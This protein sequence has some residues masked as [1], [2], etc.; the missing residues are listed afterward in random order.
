MR[1]RLALVAVLLAAA[2]CGGSADA[3]AA[4]SPAP[5]TATAILEVVSTQQARLGALQAVITASGSARAVRVA[6]L[7]AD[8]PGRIVEIF[9]DVGDRVEAEY[10]LF[11]LDPVPYQVALEEARA[12]LALARAEHSNAVQEARRVERLVEKKAI[13]HQQRDRQR[14]QA[15]VAAARVDQMEARVARMEAD[16]ARTVVRAPFDGSVV[17]RRADEGAMAGGAPVIVLQETGALEVVLDIPEVAPA[18]VRVGDRVRLFV[19]GLPEPLETRVE[20]TSDRIDPR[21]RTYEVRAPVEDASQTLKSG[22][23]VRAEVLPTPTWERPIVDRSAL[24]MRDGRTFVFR[25]QDDRVERVAVRTGTLTPDAAEIV[26]GIA[27][28]DEIVHG[29][30]V[31][32]LTDGARV[33]RAPAAATAQAPDGSPS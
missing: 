5:D 15:L 20:R 1:R 13:S 24:L 29:E 23:W 7:A 9:V 19:D 14:T 27:A 25:L 30:A 26:S 10:P 11:R 21:T 8:V 18:P 6:E 3:P 28:G 31:R 16:L 32:R 2:G 4:A 22:S 17:E 33:R 12:G